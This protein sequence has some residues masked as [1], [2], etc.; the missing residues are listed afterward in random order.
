MIDPNSIHPID[1]YK[2]I[3]DA[4][5]KPDCPD[6]NGDGYIDVDIR[7]GNTRTTFCTC[8]QGQEL[9]EADEKAREEKVYDS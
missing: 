4:L 9:L 5:E 8:Q 2:R 1:L 6:C 3:A 7:G